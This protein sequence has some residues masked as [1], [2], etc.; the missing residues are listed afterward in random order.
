MSVQVIQIRSGRLSK[1]IKD[2]KE[3]LKNP[4]A[5]SKMNQAKKNIKAK[6]ERDAIKTFTVR[7][8]KGLRCDYLVAK[9]MVVYPEGKHRMVSGL[10]LIS[11]ASKGYSSSGGPVKNLNAI[12][13]GGSRASPGAYSY[14]WDARTKLWTHPGTSPSPM[15]NLWSRFNVYSREQIIKKLREGLEEVRKSK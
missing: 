13:F 2:I 6:W 15:R 4:I 9:A 8:S 5:R 12:L 10:K 14:R 11:R 3:W 7:S 1:K